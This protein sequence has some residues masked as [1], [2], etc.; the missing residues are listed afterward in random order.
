MIWILELNGNWFA[1]GPWSKD[2]HVD[3]LKN[4]EQRRQHV[5]DGW[6][7]YQK[8][9]HF[10]TT[11]PGKNGTAYFMEEK[12]NSTKEKFQNNVNS[13]E[14]WEEDGEE[15]KIVT[16]RDMATKIFRREDKIWLQTSTN[17]SYPQPIQNPLRK[18]AFL[19]DYSAFRMRKERDPWKRTMWKWGEIKIYRHNI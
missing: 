16:D 5:Y 17:Q 14:K 9:E 8:E 3:Q 10:C 13:N 7:L 2:C 15:T 18:S 6:R 1:S 19:L 11:H 4:S 12:Q